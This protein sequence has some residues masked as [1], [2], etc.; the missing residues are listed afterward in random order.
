MARIEM[1]ITKHKSYLKIKRKNKERRIIKRSKLMI[2]RPMIN[3]NR[4]NQ[5]K[6]LINLVTVME[7]GIMSLTKKKNLKSQ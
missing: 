2:N 3:Q 4:T 6:V 1:K 7:T 5:K